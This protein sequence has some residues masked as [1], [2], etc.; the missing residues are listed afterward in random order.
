MAESLRS[1]VS[2]ASCDVSDGVATSAKHEQRQVV[3]L[4]ELDAF[5]VTFQ[6][7]VE[8]AET[9]AGER[10][11][12]ALQHDGARLVHL[13]HLRHDLQNKHDHVTT[14]VYSR[15][16]KGSCLEPAG[17]SARKTRR[18]FRREVGS[19]QHNICLFRLQYPKQQKL[20][21]SIIT[22]SK[23][24]TLVRLKQKRHLYPEVAS[25]GEI[26][27]VFVEGDRHDSVGCV[28][29]LFNAVTMVNVNIDVQHTLV[30]SVSKT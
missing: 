23:H 24:N 16:E 5:A 21:F 20:G 29:S 12:A 11:C 6:G 22:C 27:A 2:P 28:E 13:H 4:H 14:C 25:S 18:R 3:S 17:R 30:V 26:F 1:F 8:A 19:S 9:I 15:I 10:V 7:Q